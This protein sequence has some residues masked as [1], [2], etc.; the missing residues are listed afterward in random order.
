[1]VRLS[2]Y[3]TCAIYIAL[4]L[5]YY[6]VYNC[7]LYLLLP[8]QDCFKKVHIGGF[9]L[10]KVCL[11]LNGQEVVELLLGAELL[12]EVTQVDLVYFVICHT[13]TTAI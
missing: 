9:Q 8:C 3:G 6:R 1:M 7:L 12:F 5:I 11:A 13:I 2:I 4:L 10:G